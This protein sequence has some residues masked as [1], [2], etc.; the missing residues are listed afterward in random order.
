MKQPFNKE[1]NLCPFCFVNRLYNGRSRLAL[2]K[3]PS[4]SLLRGKTLP[5]SV[6]DMTISNV[7]VRLQ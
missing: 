6:L 1:Q 2:E 4:A 7:I 5:M 3:T